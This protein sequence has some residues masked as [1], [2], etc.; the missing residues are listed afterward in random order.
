MDLAIEQLVNDDLNAVWT[1]TPTDGKN[2]PLKQLTIENGHL[3]Y[4]DPAGKQIIAR[5]Q[6]TQLYQ[7]NGVAYVVTR[8]IIEK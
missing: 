4:F 5:Q 6:L 2:H 7:R 1:V 3:D 8:V